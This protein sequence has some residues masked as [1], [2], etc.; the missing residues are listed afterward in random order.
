MS[1]TKQ[2]VF[3]VANAKVNVPNVSAVN[4]D[5]PKMIIRNKPTRVITGN[6]P[7]ETQRHIAKRQK[8]LWSGH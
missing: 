6:N 4:S 2:N 5:D 3:G 7:D 8:L 1:G